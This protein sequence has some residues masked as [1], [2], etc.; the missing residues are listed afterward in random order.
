[1]LDVPTHP[2]APPRFGWANALRTTRG[3]VNETKKQQGI[4]TV[5]LRVSD[6][7]LRGMCQSWVKKEIPK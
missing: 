7:I 5:H 4:W 3:Q 1:M 6:F 2:P